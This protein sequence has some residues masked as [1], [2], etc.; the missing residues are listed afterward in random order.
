MNPT[1]QEN[2]KQSVQ[3]LTKNKQTAFYDDEPNQSAVNV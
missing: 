1:Y 3:T 2:L